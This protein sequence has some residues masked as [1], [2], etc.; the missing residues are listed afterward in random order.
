MGYDHK[1][2]A[3][4][5]LNRPPQPPASGR[6]RRWYNYYALATDLIGFVGRRFDTY[7]DIYYVPNRDGG[8]YVIRHPEHIRDVLVTHAD[9]YAKIHSA[10][11]RLARVLGQGLL[12]TDGDIWRRQRR[13]IQPAFHKERLHTYSHMMVEEARAMTSSWRDQQKIDL[14]AEFTQ[15]TLRIVSRALF[16]HEVNE[17]GDAIANAVTVLQDSFSSVDLMPRWLPNRRHNKTRRA[18]ESLDEVMYRLIAARRRDLSMAGSDRPDQPV[19]LLQRLLEARDDEGDGGRLTDK[20]IR[21]QLV[22]FFLAGHE[23]TSQALTW[24]F[25]L[26]SQNP[27]VVTRLH[28]EV[29][30]VLGRRAPRFEDVD[31]LRYTEQVVKESMRLYPPVYAIARKAIVD[32]QI[33]NYDVP[34]GSEIGLWIYMPHRDPRWFPRPESFEPERFADAQSIQ[35]MK[36]AYI[37]FGLG[38]R[39]CIGKAFATIEAVLLLATIAQGFDLSLAPGQRVGLKPRVTLIPKYGMKMIAHRRASR[40]CGIAP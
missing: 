32:T 37:P 19:D 12:N 28:A 27:R 20:E 21:D 38:A 22:T 8:L 4:T 35:R 31:A 11:V 2:P 23:T 40:D 6:L 30:G 39:T 9:C 7:G 36:Q 5:Q 18:L 1:V 34:A 33:G 24:T 14:E 15:V 10:F 29:D 3:S 16:S 26:L 25:Y 13:M 17:D